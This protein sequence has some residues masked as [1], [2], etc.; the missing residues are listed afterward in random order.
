MC[1]AAPTAPMLLEHREAHGYLGSTTLLLSSALPLQQHPGKPIRRPSQ[2]H[3]QWVPAPDLPSP[4]LHVLNSSGRR[5]PGKCQAL[6]S[7]GTGCPVCPHPFQND[8]QWQQL[9]PAAVS[10][11][12]ILSH[13]AAPVN[14]E[15]F[16]AKAVS[17][18]AIGLFR[19]TD[20]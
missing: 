20:S 7:R 8:S 14:K 10:A 9:A 2:S 17:L 15:L 6:P 13:R 5:R 3:F 11:V 18:K 4:L 12:V 1:R 19:I 16:F